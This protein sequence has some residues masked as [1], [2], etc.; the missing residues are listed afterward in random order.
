MHSAVINQFSPIDPI[1]FFPL[2]LVHLLFR[3][4]LRSTIDSGLFIVGDFG[5]RRLFVPLRL[6]LHQ[7][8][9]EIQE[10]LID[11]TEGV[12]SIRF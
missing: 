2:L 11:L 1:G 8:E 3:L 9:A 7:G 4:P 5:R 6:F 12:G 10:R